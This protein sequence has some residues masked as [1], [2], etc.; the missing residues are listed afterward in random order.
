M[1][2]EIRANTQ[3][4]VASRNGRDRTGVR[5]PAHF[6]F[7][8]AADNAPSDEHVIVTFTPHTTRPL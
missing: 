5:L 7:V 2:Y 3:S 1:K 6:F 4:P 8:T